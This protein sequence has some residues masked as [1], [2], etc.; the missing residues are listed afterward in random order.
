[1]TKLSTSIITLALLLALP[2][3]ATA[4]PTE[5]EAT[6]APTTGAAETT[7][8]E[9]TPCINSQD[10]APETDDW[11]VDLAPFFWLA[12]VN[13]S[14]GISVAETSSS[15]P[16]DATFNSLAQNL[17][18]GAMGLTRF[19]YKRFSIAADVNY[20]SLGSSTALGPPV[21]GEADLGVQMAFGTAGASFAF[22]PTKGLTLSPYLAGRWWWLGN[23]VSV[24]GGSL[25]GDGGKLSRAWA[26]PVAG[27]SIRND[28]TQ[29]W[30]VALVGD[31]GGG[32]SKVTWQV[33]GSVGYDV[34]SWF[35]LETGY[36]L[37]GVNYDRN[38]LALDV[39]AQGLLIAARF[40]L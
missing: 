8:E 33:Y 2:F 21:Q 32:V 12:G 25:D 28:I 23:T 18:A 30:H 5:G 27:L 14:I 1:M 26:D 31:V 20:M 7:S 36:R 11:S 15:V 13:G 19:R 4:S 37:I 29:K 9:P 39:V 35:G 22:Q 38:G 10:V 40:M 34:T 16:V 17:K 6:V 3:T 24:E